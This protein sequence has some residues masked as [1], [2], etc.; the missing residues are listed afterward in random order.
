LQR[1]RTLRRVSLIC[2]FAFLIAGL[3]GAFGVRTREVTATGNGYELTVTFATVTR[4]GLATPWSVDV[5]RP[6]GFDGPI[7]IAA[8]SDYLDMFDE[9]GLD[10]D[11]SASTADPEFV[12]WEFDPPMGDT[13]SVSFD[14]RIEPAQQWGRSGTVKVLADDAEVVQASF[15][16]WVMP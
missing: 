15:R 5:Q 11:P 4:P 16:T 3:A 10:P 8:T 12:V 9:N 1:S 7:T 2:I 13:L 6:G 14:A